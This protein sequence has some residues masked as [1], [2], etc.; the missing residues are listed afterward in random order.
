M[1][2]RV[3]QNNLKLRINEVS[4]TNAIV[5]IGYNRPEM[6]NQRLLNLGK[7]EGRKIY[8]SVDFES[9][10]TTEKTRAIISDGV[11]RLS[12][13]NSVSVEYQVNNLGL[14]KHVTSVITNTLKKHNNVIVIEDDIVLNEQTIYSLDFGLELMNQ[15]LSVGSVGAFSPFNLP[16][17]LH[18]INKFYTSRYFACW[19]WATSRDK[20]HHYREDL[21]GEDLQESLNNSKIWNLLSKN[22]QSTWLGRFKKVQNNPRHTWDIQFQYVSFINDWSH[23]VPYGSLVG[24]SGFS[25]NRSQHTKGPKPKWMRTPVLPFRVI[26]KQSKSHLLRSVAESL[27]SVTL[28]GDEESKVNTLRK[29]KSILRLRNK[30]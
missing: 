29:I 11:S 21:T 2:M 18:W 19:G 24:N 9:K 5:L 25:D 4:E 6:L 26:H 16:K 17:A 15:D 3:K 1:V 20:W 7:L 8:I 28:I 13:R 22:A 12:E 10:E 23:L 30:S 14:T 27:A